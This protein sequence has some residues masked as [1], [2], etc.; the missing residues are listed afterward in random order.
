MFRDFHSLMFQDLIIDSFISNVK[1]EV[2]TLVS[3][4]NT[5]RCHIPHDLNSCNPC[6]SFVS[7]FN[8]F[9]HMKVGVLPVPKHHAM[10]V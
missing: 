7:V 6:Y 10:K 3:C 4:R 1:F 9:H 2:F 8:C 5:T